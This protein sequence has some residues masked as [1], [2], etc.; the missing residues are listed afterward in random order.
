VARRTRMLIADM[1]IAPALAQLPWL[2]GVLTV[3]ED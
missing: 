1:V 3:L 2:E